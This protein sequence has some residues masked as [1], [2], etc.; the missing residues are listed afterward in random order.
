M[1]YVKVSWASPCREE[2]AL[3]KWLRGHTTYLSVI[4]LWPISLRRHFILFTNK[5]VAQVPLTS[6]K[7]P[8][9]I[10]SCTQTFA[11][12]LLVNHACWNFFLVGWSLCLAS[13]SHLLAAWS[14]FLA[15]RDLFPAG[16][17]LFLAGWSL[18]LSI[19]LDLYVSGC[20]SIARHCASMS[21]AVCRSVYNVCW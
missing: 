11:T 5:L 14:L 3:R 12:I 10:S 8:P 20:L 15:G 17:S 1:S 21:L 19:F 4:C 9:T 18:S 6:W 2:D 13:W 7:P 16:W